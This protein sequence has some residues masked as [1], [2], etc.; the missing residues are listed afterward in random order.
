[1]SENLYNILE[2]KLF[3]FVEKPGRYTGGE[4]NVIAKNNVKLNGVLC[5]P[6]LYDIG[7]SHYG[8]Q[9]LYHIVNSNENWALERAYMPWE[10]AEEIMRKNDISLY[11]LESFSP[12]KNAD[13]VGFSLQYELQYTNVLAMLDLARISVWTK[14]RGENEPIIIAG[15][16][17]SA[18]PEPIADFFDV[19][20]AGDCERTIFEFCEI[21]QNCKE[22]KT[23]RKDT[24]A[25]IAKIPNA[26]IPQNYEVKISGKFSVAAFEKSI[27]F[28]K[29]E[30]ISEKYIPQKQLAPIVETVHNRA[31]IEIMRGC[32]R[33]CRFCAAGY[34][35]RPIRERNIGDILEQIANSVK[36]TGWNEVG[37]LSLS[38][39]DYSQFAPLMC[40]LKN[41][42]L[43]GVKIGIPS[44]RLDAMDENTQTLLD[45][46]SQSSSLTIAPEAGSQRL[47]NVI[48]KDF[49][50]QK[51][52]E[53][54]EILAKRKM[55]TIK[56]YFM[57]GLPS[58]TNEDIDEMIN[59]I[60][61][62]GEIVY[63]HTKRCTLNVSLSPFS[64]KPHTPFQWEELCD[65]QVILQRGIRVKTT[66]RNIKNVNI[67][68]RDTSLS[69]CESVLARGDRELSKFI[70][71]LFL[72]GAKF[73]GWNDK[74][75]IDLWKKCAKNCGIDLEKY[76]QKIDVSQK[77][78]WSVISTGV[79]EKF[80]LEELKKAYSQITT[81]DCRNGCN[82]CGVCKDK[83]KMKIEKESPKYSIREK[84]EADFQGQTKRR[85]RISYKKIERARF[86]SH[87][88]LMDCVAR[89]LAA[90]Q[91][92]VVFS[93]GFRSRPKISFAQPLPLGAV[94]EN[95][96]FDVIVWDTEI[97]DIAKVNSL[98]PQGIELFSQK[99]I[100]IKENSIE[101]ST[102]FTDWKAE[103]ICGENSDIFFEKA[104]KDFLSQ[105][106]I[107]IKT[108]KKEED[109]IVSIIPS[110]IKNLSIN[111]GVFFTLYTNQKY[112]PA[113]IVKA[114]FPQ[115]QVFDF[116]V[117]RKKIGLDI[118]SV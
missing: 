40:E 86:I 53:T 54:T 35:Y 87:R 99:S 68:Y 7:M 84:E 69:F 83:V 39:A 60:K 80:L 58:E 23:P 14:D 28:A 56:L 88:N 24:L 67:D 3:P 16:I 89:A 63:S 91:T 104:L 34:Y 5:F 18:N 25:Q 30:E 15:G 85:V 94:G 74:L 42:N 8:S 27:E 64:P 75:S 115:N 102:I 117:I 72:H 33:G 37:L 59:L 57:I 108:R 26:Y 2:T 38:T 19:I 82:L 66:L 70:Y 114:I 96:L 73:E 51:I 81:N 97:V 111:Q 32:T 107:E 109:V 79:S 49:T 12:I 13:F 116:R 100:D 48:N 21:M 31:A 105:E 11:S 98:L 110:E 77:L 43:D 113:D 95:E 22:K 93:Q 65:L 36:N 62:C 17:V 112:R 45:E 20:F 90:S 10:D 50:T 76:T 61:K 47:R 1:M 44:T 101:Q 118:R 78:P 106:K 52:L 71:E 4:Q 103:K 9:I 92:P 41:R 55:N 46:I 29:I 6:E